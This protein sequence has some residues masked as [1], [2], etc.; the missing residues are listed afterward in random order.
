MTGASAAST[1]SVTVWKPF[2]RSTRRLRR[3][4]DG[5]VHADRGRARGH[6]ATLRAELDRG[7][8]VQ[9]AFIAHRLRG[10]SATIGASGLAAVCG[11]IEASANH[12]GPVT[13]DHLAR[14][15]A[16]IAEVTA[17]LTPHLA[18]TLDA[19]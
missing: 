8:L 11:E 18:A 6:L 14:L 12:G 5:R 15:E 4:P 1:P 10:S 2:R 3:R 7:N 16:V 19:R 13:E 9:A 17:V